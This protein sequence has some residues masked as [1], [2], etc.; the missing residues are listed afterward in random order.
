MKDQRRR[1]CDC[2]LYAVQRLAGPSVLTSMPRLSGR[3]LQV[4]RSVA[5]G[6]RQTDIALMLGLSEP[7]VE[8]HLRR[9]RKRLGATSTAQAMQL[10]VRSGGAEA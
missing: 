10:V 8:N 5:S 1:P 3:E 7:T 6:R 4:M 9:I 2:R